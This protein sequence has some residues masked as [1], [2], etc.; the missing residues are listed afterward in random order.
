MIHKAA[1]GYCFRLSYCFASRFFFPRSSHNE[2]PFVEGDDSHIWAYIYGCLPVHAVKW[3]FRFKSSIRKT[4]DCHF[5]DQ[6]NGKV[7]IFIYVIFDAAMHGTLGIRTHEFP[8][9]N[10]SLLPLSYRKQRGT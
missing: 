2:L 1:K 8:I 7:A 5:R 6:V 3:D 10:Q 4:R 9:T